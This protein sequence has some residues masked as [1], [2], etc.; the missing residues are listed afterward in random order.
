MYCYKTPH[1]PSWNWHAWWLRLWAITYNHGHGHWLLWSKGCKLA[2]NKCIECF[3]IGQTWC[4][5]HVSSNHW[6]CKR[7]RHV[8]E[9]GEPNWLV[10]H[11]DSRQSNGGI[12]KLPNFEGNS[13]RQFCLDSPVLM[14]NI[15]NKETKS[16]F[17]WADLYHAGC[18]LCPWLWW[19]TADS[20]A[21]FCLWRGV[22]VGWTCQPLT[23]Q[24]CVH[25]LWPIDLRY[26][27]IHWSIYLI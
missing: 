20:G 10:S 25:G 17:W 27:F 19:Q 18:P 14:K 21:T 24:N 3:V 6:V 5:H 2:R 13:L 22:I 26:L 11:L 12:W 23:C 9:M 15:W 7:K 1:I 16:A 8:Q 4:C